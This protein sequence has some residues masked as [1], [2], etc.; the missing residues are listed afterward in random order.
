M[1]A[2][3]VAPLGQPPVA[4]APALR[5]LPAATPV[6]VPRAPPRPHRKLCGR[7]PRLL[8]VIALVHPD[9]TRKQARRW[10]MRLHRRGLLGQVLQEATLQGACCRVF[11]LFCWF[12]THCSRR[13]AGPACEG[14]TTGRLGGMPFQSALCKVP[15][16]ACCHLLRLHTYMPF[17]CFAT[18]PAGMRASWGKSFPRTTMLETIEQAVRLAAGS[19][20]SG[21]SSG[22]AEAGG[23][24]GS[25]SQAG[26]SGSGSQAG[27]PGSASEALMTA[28]AAGDAEH[29]LA[30]RLKAAWAAA[31]A[32][33]AEDTQQEAAAGEGGSREWT[34]WPAESQLSTW[35]AHVLVQGLDLIAQQRSGA[36]W[37]P[38]LDGLSPEQLAR[39]EAAESAVLERWELWLKS[40]G[41]REND[42]LEG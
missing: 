24:S 5:P 17:R 42:V 28:I 34:S 23:G 2:A 18:L 31:S 16:L 6:A 4:A 38:S 27:G 19:S 36:P 39:G 41:E 26:G 12:G 8:F 35:P 33:D 11:T 25:G 10:L 15:H 30:W 32:E 13:G 20:G 7:L 22:S 29:A 21:S 40:P 9:T 3:A 1:A 37:R 14:A